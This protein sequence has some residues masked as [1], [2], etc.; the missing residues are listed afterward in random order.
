VAPVNLQ[1]PL[2]ASAQHI[3]LIQDKRRRLSDALLDAE[4]QFLAALRREY[5]AGD[6]TWR[7]MRNA[8]IMLSAG[9][10]PGLQA[11]WMDAI[12]VS[13][14]KVIANAK[15][16]AAGAGRVWQGR[17]PLERGQRR[18]ETFPPSGQRVVYVL[19]DSDGRPIFVGS[20]AQCWRRFATH[21]ADGMRWPRWMAYGC[22][23]RAEAFEIQ[24]RLLRRLQHRLK[25]DAARV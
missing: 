14:E 8:Y 16:E 19:L 12:P 20:T 2:H 6:T 5:E 13:P 10:L 24:A 4:L 7:Q 1:G 9:K 23:D 18:A 22:A 11:R 17:W 21:H 25:R 3:G 15:R